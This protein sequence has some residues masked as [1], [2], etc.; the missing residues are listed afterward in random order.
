ML[1]H[2]KVCDMNAIDA[3]T[4]QDEAIGRRLNKIILTLNTI[5]AIGLIVAF[6]MHHMMGA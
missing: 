5:S 1:N 3:E 6:M 4:E 2:G